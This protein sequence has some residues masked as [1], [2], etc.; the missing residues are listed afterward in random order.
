LQD[1][2]EPLWDECTNHSKLLA[3][4]WVFTIKWNYEL[5]KASYDNII[6][7]VKNILSKGNMLKDNFY[8]AKCIMKPFGLKKW[9]MPKILHVVLQWRYKFYQVQNL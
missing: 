2:D 5:S 7:W 3:I 6:K 8:V 1:F 9:Y 4:A